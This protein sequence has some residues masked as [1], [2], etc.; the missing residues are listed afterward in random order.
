MVDLGNVQNPW[1]GPKLQDW[2]IDEDAE[3]CVGVRGVLSC[4]RTSLNFYQFLPFEN[5]G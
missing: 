2:N 1:T 4:R 5:I 3:T